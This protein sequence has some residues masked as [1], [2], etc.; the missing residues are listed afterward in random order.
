MA[1]LSSRAGLSLEQRI[2][3]AALM[4]PPS[5]FDATAA[6]TAWSSLI[7]SLLLA[8]SAAGFAEQIS[9]HFR[10]HSVGKDSTCFL[11]VDVRLCLFPP[12]IGCSSM[13][14]PKVS[15]AC[16]QDGLSASFSISLMR[17]DKSLPVHGLAALGMCFIN[18]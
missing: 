10:V 12:R 6:A 15:N 7:F 13:D 3:T 16:Q 17:V 11:T 8:F 1:F 9:S 2:L 4:L 14:A 18:L 5:S